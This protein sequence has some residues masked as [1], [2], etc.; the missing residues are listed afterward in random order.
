MSFNYIF[1]HILINGSVF[2]NVLS[3]SVKLQQDAVIKLLRLVTN[4]DTEPK[5]E[6]FC[7]IVVCQLVVSDK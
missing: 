7:I 6:Q 1:N 4:Y 3:N 5:I 2:V